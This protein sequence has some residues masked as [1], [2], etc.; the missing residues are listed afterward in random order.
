MKPNCFTGCH[1]IRKSALRLRSAE[2]YSL[3]EMLVY[4]GVLAVLTG[5]GYSALYSCMSNSTALRR[6]ADDIVNAIHAGENWRLDVRAAG[7][8]V[9]LSTNADE[10]VLHLLGPGRDVSY[11]FAQSTLSRRLGTNGWSAVLTN[12]AGCN[13][14][15]DPRDG[16]LAW[17][18]ELELQKRTTKLTRVRPLFTFMAVPRETSSVK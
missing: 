16:V 10:Q 13:F 4:I 5:V 8:A 2:A 6:N 1:S 17:R 9:R 18:W 11:R 12:V 14:I 3:I 15:S 7:N